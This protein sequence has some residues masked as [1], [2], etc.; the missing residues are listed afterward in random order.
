MINGLPKVGEK[1]AVTLSVKKNPSD[2]SKLNLNINTNLSGNT[3]SKILKIKYK[4]EMEM[5]DEKSMLAITG[6]ADTTEGLNR[7]FRA[8]KE[9]NRDLSFREASRDG[10]ECLKIPTEAETVFT[11]AQALR[12]ETETVPL[13]EAAGRIAGEFFTVYPPGIPLLVPGEKI[14]NEIIGNINKNQ[15]KVLR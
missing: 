9:I 11:P 1:K 12:L 5:A 10:D 4:L 3:V 8:V 6:V 15:I 7:L 13:R 14:K 2:I